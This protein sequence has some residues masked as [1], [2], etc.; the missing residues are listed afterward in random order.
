M[1]L[2]SL[3][4]AAEQASVNSVLQMLLQTGAN[5]ALVLNTD[6]RLSGIITVVDILTAEMKDP[7]TTAPVPREVSS[8]AG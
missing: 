5:K 8:D 3:P 2:A 7:E 4:T 1:P 6:Q